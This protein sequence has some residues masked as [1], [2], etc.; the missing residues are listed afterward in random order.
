MEKVT[1]AADAALAGE[2]AVTLHDSGD[3][4]EHGDETK[5]DGIYSGRLALGKQFS[6]GQAQIAFS[7]V[8][9][10]GTRTEPVTMSFYVLPPPAPAEPAATGK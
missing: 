8:L 2:Q 4:I 3:V 5:G 9:P 6:V 7:I 10:D 1:A